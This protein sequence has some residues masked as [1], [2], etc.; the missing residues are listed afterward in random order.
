MLVPESLVQAI[1]LLSFA[2]SIPAVFHA[3]VVSYLRAKLCMAHITC[4]T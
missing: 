4:A 3:K 1:S 2:L